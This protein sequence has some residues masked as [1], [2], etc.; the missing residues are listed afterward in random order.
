MV[1]LS[2]TDTLCQDPWYKCNWR[3]FPFILFTIAPN[4]LSKPVPPS[5][6][7]LF[8]L[9]LKKSVNISKTNSRKHF[10]KVSYFNYQSLVNALLYS[11]ASEIFQSVNLALSLKIM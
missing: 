6:I 11:E 5:A 8:C 9:S 7:H 3:M 1:L 4:L 10:L 2:E